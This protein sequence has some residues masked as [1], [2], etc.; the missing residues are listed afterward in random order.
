MNIYLDQEGNQIKTKIIAT[1]NGPDDMDYEEVLL[2]D[3]EKFESKLMTE[4][5]L[6]GALIY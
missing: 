3:S 5:D 6:D 2:S 4:A 1:Q